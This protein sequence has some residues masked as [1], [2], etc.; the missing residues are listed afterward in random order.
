MEA[1][2]QVNIENVK[3]LFECEVDYNPYF[4]E[5]L[6]H[7]KVALGMFYKLFICLFIY[8]HTK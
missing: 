1:C 6:F 5:K 4:E 3:R 7:S 2:T 8:F